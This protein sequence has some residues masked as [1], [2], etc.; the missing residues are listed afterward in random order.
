MAD[1]IWLDAAHYIE[2]IWQNRDGTMTGL[3]RWGNKGE[4]RQMI[5]GR[6]RHDARRARG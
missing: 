2:D 6:D 4:V 3:V 5:S 1:K